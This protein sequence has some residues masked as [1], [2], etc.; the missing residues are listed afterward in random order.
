[1]SFVA[2]CFPAAC[3]AA[4]FCGAKAGAPLQR[5]G[6]ISSGVQKGRVVSPETKRKTRQRAQEG[7]KE[8]GKGGEGKGEAGTHARSSGSR[9]RA[10]SAGRRCTPSQSRACSP[11][12]DREDRSARRAQKGAA[13]RCPALVAA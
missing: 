9:C 13:R 7:Q 2:L 6:A 4:F 8:K 5:F 12:V 3:A 10:Q 11:R 1:M